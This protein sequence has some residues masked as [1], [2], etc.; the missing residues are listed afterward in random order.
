MEIWQYEKMCTS[1]WLFCNPKYQLIS[2][3]IVLSSLHLNLI[4]LQNL[5]IDRRH[6][7][8]LL[9]VRKLCENQW[10]CHWRIVLQLFLVRPWNYRHSF[11]FRKILGYNLV[12]EFWNFTYFLKF[13]FDFLKF[14][15]FSLFLI[16][17]HSFHVFIKHPI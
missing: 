12:F 14:I 7:L 1:I 8:K 10:F 11:C 4:E 16:I 15:S 17:L 3:I 9:R 5:F 13:V 6:Y 2:D